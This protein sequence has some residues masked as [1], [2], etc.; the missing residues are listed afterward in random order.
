MAF[1]G[2]SPIGL[3][4]NEF[5]AVGVWVEESYQH[6]GIGK[7]LLNE[8]MKQRKASTKIGQMTSSG[9]N[10]TKSWLKDRQ[11]RSL[12]LYDSIGEIIPLSERF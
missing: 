7:T 11:D 1:V 5:G 8:H 3:A 12:V 4:S 10:M 2:D 6:K 9:I